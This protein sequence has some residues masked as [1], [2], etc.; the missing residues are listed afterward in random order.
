MT[1]TSGPVVQM[2]SI[3]KRKTKT[4]WCWTQMIR[5]CTHTQIT[6]RSHGA[7]RAV[8]LRGKVC[9]SFMCI[10]AVLY[11]VV[12]HQLFLPQTRCRSI[13]P[14]SCTQIRKFKWCHSKRVP[15]MAGTR[16]RL[17]AACETSIHRTTTTMS[18]NSHPISL[19]QALQSLDPQV[20]AVIEGVVRLKMGE[21]EQSF[22]QQVQA[23]TEAWKR[24]ENELRAQ[25]AAL[26]AQ[27]TDLTNQLAMANS[28]PRYVQC[29]HF[30]FSRVYQ[31][32]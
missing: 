26:Q 23:Q 11:L 18:D 9:C 22:S 24:H 16:V 3:Y 14:F 32:C 6:A 13:R 1:S 19:E 31:R 4:R 17:G 2:L 21:A 5:I 28:Q 29:L 30:F 12:T 25:E 8:L 10:L 7:D 15:S 27:V 20:L